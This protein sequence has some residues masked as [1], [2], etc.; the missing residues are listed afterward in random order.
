VAHRVPSGI[1]VAGGALALIPP[2]FVIPAV[3]VVFLLVYLYVFPERTGQPRIRSE[4]TAA[5]P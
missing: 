3:G 2:P 1:A 4:G 5:N